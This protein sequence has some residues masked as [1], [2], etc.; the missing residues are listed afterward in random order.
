MATQQD[1]DALTSAEL[2]ASARGIISLSA[3][4]RKTKSTLI[5]AILAKSPQSFLE[6]LRRQS[7]QKKKK[8]PHSSVDLP[9]SIH[10]DSGLH[11]SAG[12]PPRALPRRRFEEPDFSKFLQLPS[13]EQTHHLYQQFYDATSNAALNTS[14]CSICA[15]ERNVADDGIST[16]LLCDIPNP[17]RLCPKDATSHPH[18]TLFSNMLL[19]PS[20]KRGVSASDP[21]GATLQ[22]G[23]RGTVTTYEQD[24]KG[25]TAMTEGKRMPRPVALLA[26]VMSV[27]FVGR[28][29]LPKGWLYSTFK[30]RRAAIRE[31]LLWLREHNPKYYGDI[32][33]DEE[34]LRALP[35]DD[36]PEEVLANVRQ[37]EDVG[38]LLEESGAGYV[39]DETQEVEYGAY[40]YHDRLPDVIPLLV[41][42]ASDTD[43][44][45]VTPTELMLYGLSNLWNDDSEG[46]YAVRR[47]TDPVS[48]FGRPPRGEVRPYDPNRTNFFERAFPTLF[49]YGRG[50]V[51]ADRETLVSYQDHIRWL[52]Q[53]H[54][55]R[56][57]RHNTFPFVAFGIEQR[58][59]GLNSARIQMRRKNF[60][61]D[62]RLLSTITKE[63]LECA[64]EE[65]SK[66][67]PISDPA[68]RL[69]RKHIHATGARVKG[70]DHSRYSL[71]SQIWSTT[72]VKGPPTVWM[73]IN[74]NDLHD[75]I[76]QIFA[77]EEID[78]ESFMTTLGP[79]KTKR[80]ANIADDPYAAAKFFH[81]II[82]TILETLFGV[83]VTGGKR[84]VSEMGVLGEI[85][86][87]FGVVE[88]QGRGTLHLHILF[89]LLHAP[90]SEEMHELLQSEDFRNRVKTYISTNM[91]AYLP[92]LSSKADAASVPNETEIGYNR[93]PN[94]TASDYTEQL[95]SF[96][97]RVV[98][99]TQVHKCE[100]RRCL[101][102]DQNGKYR[103]KRGA[104]FQVA[105]HDFIDAS[106]VWG[107]KRLF[108]KLNTW[109]RAISINVRC[110][111]DAKFLTSGAETKNVVF[112]VSTYQAKKQ[113]RSHTASALMAQGHAYHTE[114]TDYTDSLENDQRKLLIR[115]LQTINRHQELSGPMV[116]SYLMGWDD[117]Y[118]SHHYTPIYWSS[119]SGAIMRTF[120]ELKRSR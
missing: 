68:V 54:D 28:G 99:A 13:V 6:T 56:F 75:P 35:E 51:E 31:A 93:P 103:C 102:L 50:G 32:E 62:A 97:L 41:S 85:A 22:R 53:Y 65:E 76:A 25:V 8:R 47:G 18:H 3:E 116:V 23:M 21:A 106:G 96:E 45:G 83:Q 7:V 16:L 5:T 59:Q 14:T 120:P 63:K 109:N 84:V 12:E 113:N 19:E 73:T 104:P 95:T 86:A 44:S 115:I 52:L 88:S 15:R 29:K 77:G 55:R 66:N 2:K 24:I 42:G 69:L 33:I 98:R 43:L 67:R 26:S 118:K 11:S 48:D 92:G 101:I 114:H 71:R 111:N 74:P 82:R 10:T 37:T 112:Y 40:P 38:V 61:A 4:E 46:G 60:D 64:V 36:V 34:R 94:P 30:V 80:A 110:N 105:E 100:L 1:L 70:S 107:P 27:T 58:R 17:Q 57:R 81:F 20:G 91:T 108:D 87:Y 72:V 39:P 79:D 89:W 119:F 78:M 49:P 90:S 117:T 9:Q